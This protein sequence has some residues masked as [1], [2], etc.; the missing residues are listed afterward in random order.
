MT[1]PPIAPRTDDCR[2]SN[3][4]AALT[5]TEV[6]VDGGTVVGAGVTAVGG[7]GAVVVVVVVATATACEE[8]PELAPDGLLATIVKM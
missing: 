8:T 6:V 2:Q 3:T 5:G 1:F 4:D 7:A